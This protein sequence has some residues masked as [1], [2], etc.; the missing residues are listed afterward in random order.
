MKNRKI[1][2]VGLIIT[3]AVLIPCCV[4]GGIFFTHF[5]IVNS[6]PDT[7]DWILVNDDYTVC[8]VINNEDVT[9]YVE[10]KNGNTVF[11]ADQGWRDWD[12]KYI[13]IDKN[14]VITVLSGDTGEYIYKT[15][16]KG[17]FYLSSPIY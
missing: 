10:D 7:S 14:N 5:M 4:Y 1:L 9:F 8:P 11:E 15:N 3:I 6:T 16:D 2:A 12:F 13:N 17:S